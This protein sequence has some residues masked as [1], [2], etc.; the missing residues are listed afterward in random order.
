[1]KYVT[2]VATALVASATNLYFQGRFSGPEWTL[3]RIR[4]DWD[5]I[6]V[7][8]FIGGLTALVA[9]FVLLWLYGPQRRRRSGQQPA[10]APLKKGRG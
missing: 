2:I 9:P 10:D 8:Q 5:W 3:A 1:M 4:A 7:F 6:Y